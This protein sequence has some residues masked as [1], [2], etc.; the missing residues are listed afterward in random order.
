MAND[1]DRKF[2]LRPRKPVARGERRVFGN[3]IQNH[4]ASRPDERSMKA[5]PDFPAR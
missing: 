1:E 5:P 2:R 4:H 3:G